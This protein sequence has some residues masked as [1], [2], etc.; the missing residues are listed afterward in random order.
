MRRRITPS[1]VLSLVAVVLA[2][3]GSA[4][5][6]GLITGKQVKDSSLSG[7]DVKNKSLTPADFKGSVQGAR[8]AQGPQGVPGAAGAA[9]AAGPAGAQ[10]P[11]G[12][13]GIAKIV[14]AQGNG[15]GLAM[16]YCPAGTRPVSGGGINDG[17][18]TTWGY[19][20][21][22]GA[23]SD[24]GGVGWLVAGEPSDSVTAFAYCSSGVSSFTFPNGTVRSESGSSG[25]LSP[26]KIKA[27]W[28]KRS[29]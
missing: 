2:C 11:V 24:S 5:A 14:A 15:T 17:T 23:A 13:T 27:L 28:A 12:P 19:L 10:G 20:I 26:E 21:A 29:Q 7:K 25:F 16:A 6:G 18:S 9:G 1:L 8:G 3:T 4:V 22:S